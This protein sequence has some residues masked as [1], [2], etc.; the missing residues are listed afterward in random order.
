MS[1]TLTP[2]ATPL[3]R[4]ARER[5]V[6]HMEGV[7]PELSEAVRTALAESMHTAQSS[8]DMHARRDALMD[9]E[10]EAARWADATVRAWRRAIVPPTATGRVRM[11]LQSLELIGDDVVENKILSSRLAMAVQEK[12]VWDLNDLR[13]RITH[14]EGGE[15]LATEDVLRPEAL[16]QLMVEQWMACKLS[17]ETRAAAKDIIALHVTPRAVQGYR[18]VNEFLIGR[19]VLPEIDL[20]ARV[21]RPPSSPTRP[22][23]VG[24]RAT[25]T[26]AAMAAMARPR[27]RILAAATRAATVASQAATRA[28][29]AA[30][31][32][33]P[34]ADGQAGGGYAGAPGGGYPGGGGGG[35][36]GGQAGGYG[37]YGGR[38]GPAGPQG[39]GGAGAAGGGSPTARG[40]VADETRM[41]TN[42]TPLARA[43]RGPPASSAS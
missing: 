3:A 28:A 33:A 2:A 42:T 22:G 15:D 36:G 1:S 19:G 30:A 27:R 41:M 8:R 4:Q 11:Q 10:K 39:P 25:M 20:S 26:A 31:T 40:G 34:P 5:F 16:A 12:A 21:K 6:A 32:P 17:R 38:G 35:G 7:L 29:A 18:D 37:G 9:F 13:L 24:G 23:S 14:L 43:G